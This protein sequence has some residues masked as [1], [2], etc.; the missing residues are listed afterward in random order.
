MKD[1]FS[2]IMVSNLDVEFCMS[3][4]IYTLLYYFY[5]SPKEE[6]GGTYVLLCAIFRLCCS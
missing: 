4:E 1:H 2:E 6:N 3:K 5:V